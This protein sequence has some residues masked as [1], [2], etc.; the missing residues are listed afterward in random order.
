MATNIQTTAFNAHDREPRK[1]SAAG[2]T[3]RPLSMR[4]W[5][6]L[7]FILAP[8]ASLKLTVTLFALSIVLIFAGTLAQVDMDIWEVISKYFRCWIALIPIQV[9]IP[10][11]FVVPLEIRNAQGVLV[12]T[13]YYFMG[14]IPLGDWKANDLSGSFWFP[15]GKLIGVLLAANLLSAHLIRFK[16]DVR[17]RRLLFGVVAIALGC[18]GTWMIIAAGGNSQGI[19]AE[20]LVAYHTLWIGFKGLIALLALSAAYG[21]A[22]LWSSRRRESQ[23]DAESLRV[24][25]LFLRS[26]LSVSAIGLAALSGY[27]FWKGETTTPS[28]SALRILWQLTQSAV[29]GAA[30]LGGCW[31]VF[32]RKAGIV[33]LHAGVGLMMYYELHVAMTAVET[34]MTLE[35]GERSNFVQ[36][37]RTFELA[38]IDRSD[39][40]Q[41][42]VVAIPRSS[43]LESRPIDIAE[44]PFV[45]EIKKLIANSSIVAAPSGDA[46]PATKGLGLKW[47]AEEKKPGSG[48]DNDSKI[49][50][51][52]A[53]I[54]LQPREGGASLGTYLTGML[55][56]MSGEM[57]TIRVGQKLY[58]LGLR[59]KRHYKS[60][61]FELKDVKKEDYLGTSTPKNYASTV[62]IVDTGRSVNEE[63]TIWMNN[64]LRFAN[65]T[66]YQSGYHQEKNG[67][68]HTTLSVVA[69]SGWMMPYVSCALVALG[70]LSH[71]LLLLVRF[72]THADAVELSAT[73]VAATAD[74]KTKLGI[75]TSIPTAVVL[76]N[77][78]PKRSRLSVAMATII[79]SAA[80]VYIALSAM[81]PKTSVLEYDLAAFGRIPVVH[82]GR[83]K[84]LDS[85]AQTSLLEISGRTTVPVGEGKSK[86]RIPAI[87]WLLNVITETK[88]AE[89][90]PAFR[91]ENLELH[92]TMGVKKR[93]GMRYSRKELQ[94]RCKL[95]NELFAE[96]KT[97]Q[98]P[99]S[100]LQKLDVLK[101]QRLE[102]EAFRDRLKDVLDENEFKRFG[103]LVLQAAEQDDFQKQVN[104]AREAATKDRRQLSVYK[105]K[106]LELSD[107][108]STY[109]NLQLAFG[110]QHRIRGESPDQVIAAFKKAIE[111]ERMIAE[112]GQPVFAIGPANS[113]QTWRTLA[114]AWFENTLAEIRDKKESDPA[115]KAWEVILKAY[116]KNEP[117]SFNRAVEHY[118]QKIDENPPGNV[119]PNAVRFEAFFNRFQPF[120]IA[121]RLY[122]LAF[123]LAALGWLGWTRGFNR[124]AFW[125]LVLVLTLHTFAL[126]GRI[127]ISG[128]PPVTNLYSS[129][130]FIGWGCVVLGLILETIYRIG[131]GSL[132]ASVSGYATL[133]IA[134]NLASSGDTFTVLQAVL[135]TQFWLATHVTCITFGYATTYLA[136]LLGVVYVLRGVVT[137]SLTREVARDLNRMI[138]GTL[139][140]SI[141]F[142]FVGTVLGGLWADDSWGRFWGWDPKENGALIIVLWNALAL[143]ARWGGLVKERGLA[144]I[145]IA[146]NIFVSWSWWGVNELGA[147]LHSYGFTEGT[148]RNLGLFVLSQLALIAIGMIP[149]KF[150]RSSPTAE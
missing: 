54:E 103:P 40:N 111:F 96:L 91:I 19:Q 60:Y 75:K 128:R 59:P 98:I 69:N 127:Y 23:S 32:R 53:Y 99:D 34:Q 50:M 12:E 107:K 35:E 2:A 135:D 83:I 121:N 52:A 137:K 77:A 25:L 66:F 31:T 44:L 85:A 93:E 94:P 142:S 84:P 80:G 37:I 43:L 47:F 14:L 149:R 82:D 138:Y 147:G 38:V 78:P 70:M 101:D 73:Q 97:A 39:R 57:D 89:N 11:S 148:I 24:R 143:H 4:I 68:E 7:K 124:I 17:G 117:K 100:V 108:L 41:D 51:A 1:T 33:L 144:V 133:L 130:V 46:N 27:L 18:L 145:A 136:G 10:P 5:D 120:A 16:S 86:T 88:D 141:F 8:V 15:G 21:V 150:W 28:D 113:T 26:L 81:P 56:S 87:Q 65:E 61:V 30:L 116:E 140:F 146:G 20:P 123:T 13:T 134:D 64:P 92:E 118:L 22:V 126:I 63:K 74:L 115:V 132:I 62:A 104:D 67:T 139:C 29:A 72:L 48:V 3:G 55:L 9:F 6:V 76:S 95:S 119:N 114:G 105:K 122:L 71:F 106:V 102:S 110:L 45:I 109:D 125:L 90:Y 58:E 49:D 42:H 79:V 36:D 129:A 131:I 112:Q